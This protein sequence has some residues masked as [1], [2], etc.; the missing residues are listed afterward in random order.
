[1]V[2]IE[3]CSAFGS[4]KAQSKISSESKGDDNCADK[5]K[6]DKKQNK[7][8]KDI[9]SN[10]DNLNAGILDNGA[11]RRDSQSVLKDREFS[12]FPCFDEISGDGNN[13]NE[14]LKKW[15][16]VPMILWI[17]HVAGRF[18]HSSYLSEDY[19]AF[20]IAIRRRL[21]EILNVAT[22][23]KIENREVRRIGCGGFG[24]I[25][26]EVRLLAVVQHK[27]IVRYYGAW[28]ELRDLQTTPSGEDDDCSNDEMEVSWKN[29][30]KIFHH[31]LMLAQNLPK[32][33][34]LPIRSK[35]ILAEIED[36]DDSEEQFGKVSI[37]KDRFRTQSSTS[38]N[39]M[40]SEGWKM[41]R[42]ISSN[43]SLT[44][45]AIMFVQ[46]E[47]C[48]RTLNDYF[49]E[50]NAEIRPKKNRQLNRSIM[51]QLMSAPSNIFL[52]NESS[53]PIPSI[54]L[55]D[56]GLAC[57]HQNKMVRN[58]IE[59]ET[60]TTHSEG[61]GTSLYAAPE[62]QNS[63]A[64]DNAAMLI[65]EMCRDNPQKRPNAS[66]IVTKLG[67]IGENTESLK[68]RIQ[69]LE[70]EIDELIGDFLGSLGDIIG[71]DDVLNEHMLNRSHTRSLCYLHVLL[72]GIVMITRLILLVDN[73]SSVLP[74]FISHMDVFLDYCRKDVDISKD[75]VINELLLTK[76]VD[77]IKHYVENKG[78]YENVTA[79]Y[80]RMSGIYW[81]LQAMDLMGKLDEVDINEIAV[82]V[83]QCQQP[84]GGFACAEQHDAHLLQ[85]LSA[86]QIMIMLSKL[87]EIDI[88]AVA[89]YVTSLQ[90]DDG[91]FGGDE[92]NEIDTRFSF[93]ALA[94]LHLIAID[95]VLHCYNFDGGFGA[96]P[97][98][99][100]HAGQVYCCLG[101]LAIADCLEMIDVQRTARWLAERQCLSGGLNG[102]PE[103]LPDVCYS[104]WVLA[105]L[106]MIGRLHWIDNKSMIKFI[107][108]CQDSDGGFA[109]RPGDVTDPFHTVF[110]LAG[111][112][113][114]GAYNE[115][116]VAIDPVF[117][118]GKNV[119][120]TRV[121]NSNVPCH[122]RVTYCFIAIIK[123][124]V[125]DRN[126][127]RHVA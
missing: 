17:F 30:R 20:R 45:T 87:D 15:A 82:Y 8:V 83:K 113:L 48:S 88:D 78:S 121:R 55:G 58:T 54:L 2:H 37:R 96:R 111:L 73:V 12:E 63:T 107:L 93:C 123:L 125:L 115:S 90:N 72:L 36:E 117:C 5:E 22:N 53:S 100:S 6:A 119:L 24:Q 103:K 38:S 89:C 46:M 9:D 118:M 122:H 52:R 51:E 94:T 16:V 85:T 42:N 110:G 21:R 64:Y 92:C 13:R 47:L 116:L 4:S 105:S 43:R 97:G 81:C 70:K 27:N 102:R 106:R 57:L 49:T 39:S 11:I 66:E 14:E 19:G 56:F 112:S 3:E 101:S 34:V 35:K 18:I 33:Y 95:F 31:Q 124:Y 120:D 86:I 109:D 114:L 23:L 29:S 69:E 91:S 28:V 40:I 61:V 127:K 67:K 76:H 65:Q 98:S 75:A 104:W 84:S 79:E 99:E 68:D 60:I 32:W 10:T 77:F 41:R 71:S 62:Q 74:C 1:M 126:A 108:A 7:N 80:L 59:N 44:G 26:N 25:V 50:R